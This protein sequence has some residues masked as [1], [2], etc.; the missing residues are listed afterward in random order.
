M[1]YA[2]APPAPL[3][4]L[5]RVF[6]D[7]EPTAINAV[8]SHTIREQDLYMLDPCVRDIEPTNVFSGLDNDIF[9]L[10]TSFVILLTPNP[11][12][13]ALPVYLLSYF[14]QLQMLAADYACDVVLEYHTLFLSRRSREM[15]ASGD[16]SA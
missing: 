5:S 13:H 9:P 1:G 2:F 15:A 12:A 3:L 14:T 16:Y 6:P 10:H 4:L 11:N 7:I 8:L